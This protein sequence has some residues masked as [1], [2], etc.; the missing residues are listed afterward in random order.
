[1]QGDRGQLEPELDSNRLM[2]GAAADQLPAMTLAGWTG[3]SLLPGHLVESITYAMQGL[4]RATG[5]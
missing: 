5:M 3:P 1:M 2:P 4:K